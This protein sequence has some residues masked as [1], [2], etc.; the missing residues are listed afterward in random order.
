MTWRVDC[1]KAY[2]RVFNRQLKKEERR[3]VVVRKLLI[4]LPPLG[5][6]QNFRMCQLRRCGETFWSVTKEAFDV[7]PWWEK[8]APRPTGKW[9]KE[10]RLGSPLA[11]LA[12][13]QGK[14]GADEGAKAWRALQ[15]ATPAAAA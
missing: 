2:P 6:P 8:R 9:D 7:P 13:L 3:V 14:L 15:T 4:Q 12:W 1:F 10:A 5:T 11:A